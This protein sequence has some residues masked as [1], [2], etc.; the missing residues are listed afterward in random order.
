MAASCDLWT[1]TREHQWI[2]PAELAASLEE[3]ARRGDLDFRTR[4]LIRDSLES[5]SQYWGGNRVREWLTRSTQQEVLEQIW[6]SDL[7]PAGFPSLRHRIMEPTRPETV[8]Q[9][10]RELGAKVDRRTRIDVGGSIALIFGGNLSRNTEDIDVVDEV[11]PDIRS[12]HDLLD[13]LLR[14]YGLRLAHFQSH[15]L[16]TGWADRTRSLGRFGNLDVYLVDPYDVLVGKL[17]S[18]REKDLDDVR[19]IGPQLDRGRIEAILSGS[20]AP[21]LADAKL[22]ANAARN[23]YIVFGDALPGG[24]AR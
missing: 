15:Y 3:Q 10:L 2:D 22:A 4:L 16:P 9:F 19:A 1:L 20:A 23:W 12:Q 18:A 24:A 11:P 17:F 8:L 6:Q 21:L 7:G 5:L 14:R 13:G